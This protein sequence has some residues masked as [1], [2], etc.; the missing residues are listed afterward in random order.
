MA[1]HMDR[2]RSTDDLV[3]DLTTKLNLTVDQ[4]A[5]VQVDPG[6]KSPE[7]AKPP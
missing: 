6:R 2:M 7:N 4:Q 1:G 3:K 5:K